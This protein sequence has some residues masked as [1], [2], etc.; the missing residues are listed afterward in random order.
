MHVTE[1]ITAVSNFAFGRKN[2]TE[3]DRQYYLFLLN[4]A[5]F[6]YHACTKNSKYLRYK[7]D[8]FFDPANDFANLDDI[9]I[10]AIY[11]NK[12]KL[13]ELEE[14]DGLEFGKNGDYYYMDKQL[15]IDKTN[16]E[17]KLDPNDGNVKQY[18]TLLVQR[19]R[20]Q[21]VEVVANFNLE[22]EIPIYPKQYHMGLVHGATYLLC[23]T[24]E[25][26]STKTNEAIKNWN[27]AKQLLMSH[28]V[29]GV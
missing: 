5:D 18:V 6:E 2:P 21:L 19:E 15:F 25:G 26:F 12:I 27:T 29:K 8:L 23:L 7:L 16:L 28:Y 9:H 1:L 17:S 14:K 13:K 10:H 4:L 24:H 22:T 20:K 11:N 3:S